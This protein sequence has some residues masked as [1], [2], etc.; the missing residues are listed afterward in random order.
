MESL[1][2]NKV[3][4][5]AHTCSP[6]WM[7]VN[8]CHHRRSRMRRPA[9]TWQ[10][11][12]WFEQSDGITINRLSN[13]VNMSAHS[14]SPKWVCHHRRSRMRRPAMT[15]QTP[16]C[17]VQWE[18]VMETRWM[19][20]L[21]SNKVNMSAH[22]CSPKWMKVNMCHHRRSRM[23]RPAMTWQTPHCIEQWE[24]VMETHNLTAS[25]KHFQ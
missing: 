21:L 4:M 8:M 2:S 17:I 3:N 22:T 7:K 10:T 5:S 6:K 15:W 19:E 23:R 16:H 12:H 1:L 24:G 20:S 14:C 25:L 18:G 11:P 9:M 13:M